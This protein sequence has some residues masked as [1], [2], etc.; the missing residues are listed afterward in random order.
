M[1]KWLVFGILTAIIIAGG[2]ISKENGKNE[3]ATQTKAEDIKIGVLITQTGGLGPIGEGMANGAKLAAREINKEGISGRNVTLII[4]DTGTN[5]AKAAEAAK[6]LIEVDNV[7]VIIGGVASSE[8]L[9]VAPMA[10]KSKVVL[11]SPSSTAPSVTDAGEYVFRVIGS[12]N[13]QGDAI[14]QLAMAKNFTKP[15]VLFENND[16]GV[17]LE[18][19]FKEK[20][21]GIAISSIQYE[22]GKADYRS[23]L[24]AIKQVNPDVIVYVG[25]PAEASTILQQAKQLG[26]KTK[27]IAAEGIADP[28]MFDNKEVA[29]QM[30]GMYLTRPSSP[31]GNP[32]YQNFKN[33][34]REAFGKD[35]GIYSDTEFDATMLAAQA[36]KEAGNEGEKIKNALPAVSRR[37]RAVT[38]D[39]AFDANGDVPQEYTVLE[40]RNKTMV[41][42]GNW[43][44]SSGIKLQ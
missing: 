11:I 26:L 39:K 40:V 20:F 5:P 33:L 37:Y 41:T 31:E 4:E 10:D 2:C 18:K 6:K 1:Q 12:D 25:Y 36:I 23:E 19:V 21:E 28:V 9:A 24:E 42:I 22:K 38:G 13:L 34:Y 17:G 7:Q 14:A 44:R 35:P 43:S 15:V 3:T 8:T 32:E 30:E 29:A 16:Y 27:W